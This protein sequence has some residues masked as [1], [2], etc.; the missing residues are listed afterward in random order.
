MRGTGCS[1]HPGPQSCTP[2]GKFARGRAMLPRPRAICCFTSAPSR[3]VSA[4]SWRRRSWLVCKVR[5]RRSTRSTAFVTSTTATFWVLSTGPKVPP[6]RRR[7]DAALIGEEDAAFAGGSYVVVQK[8]L[9][10]LTA[11]NALPTEA[12]ERIIGR[13]KLSDIELDDA[14]KPSFGA[15]CAE[16]DRG[17]REGDQDRAPQHGFR[18]G[19]PGRVRH[20]LHR[21]QPV[22]AH[23]RA[24][25]RKH[26]R[27]P[28]AR[29]LR[30][31][32]RLQPG[33]HRH[34]LLCADR[35]VSGGADARSTD[36]IGSLRRG[37]RRALAIHLPR[38]PTALSASA[39]SKENRNHEQP[40]PRACPDLG[41][42][43]G[44]DR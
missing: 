13:T 41:C 21:L 17:G 43:V 4:S 31:H 5:Y 3:W 35:D 42:G 14:V 20:L 28:A 9:H 33:G 6:G 8:Y 23:D 26:V 29:Q 25:A 19:G 2:F 44:G 10:D 7:S 11:W 27:R 38:C 18:S 24:D 1:A 30:S 36:R 40:A 39:R 34:S 22:A 15:C 12:Q 37:Q 16:Q 32:S